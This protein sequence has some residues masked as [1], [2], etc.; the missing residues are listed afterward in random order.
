M[1]QIDVANSQ[2]FLDVDE[3]FVRDVVT[4]TL[5]AEQVASSAVSIAIV[6]NATIRP[7][8]RTHLSHDYDTDV[9]SFLFERKPMA[10]VLDV[11]RQASLRGVG[12]EIEGEVVVSA[13]MALQQ[14]FR[15]GWRPRDELTLYL[16]HGLL[17]LVGYDDDS[18][19]EAAVMR[20]R[21]RAILALWN[22][23]P[24]GEGADAETRRRGDTGKETH[25]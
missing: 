15:Y 14:A 11:G 13:E 9:L 2:S 1:Y 3:A 18:D 8:N 22:L 17:H 6:D 12:K 25:A 24:V 7:L 16:I 4:R 19:E 21:E 10:G 5:A 20:Q 23:T